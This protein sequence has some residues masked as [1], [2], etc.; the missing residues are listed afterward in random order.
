MFGPITGRTSVKKR[1]KDRNGDNYKG[2]IWER[3]RER[4]VIKINFQNLTV[5]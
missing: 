2:T 1:Q 5:R 4:Q 3:E